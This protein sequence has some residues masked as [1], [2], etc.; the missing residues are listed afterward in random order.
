MAVLFT[1]CDGIATVSGVLACPV[2]AGVFCARS[3]VLMEDELWD[4]ELAELVAVLLRQK[5]GL[6]LPL[7]LLV[8]LGS[9]LLEPAG[10][11]VAASP[12]LRSRMGQLWDS[13]P[14]MIVCHCQWHA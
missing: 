4:V 6:D 14:R 13:A 5:G 12:M 11:G 10:P 7:T 2:A 8:W 9:S 1:A 3:G